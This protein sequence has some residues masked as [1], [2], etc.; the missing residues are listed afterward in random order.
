MGAAGVNAN[1]RG[2]AFL[3]MAPACPILGGPWS[4]ERAF[5]HLRDARN[6]S[7]TKRAARIVDTHTLFAVSRL[8]R[9]ADEAH[10]SITTFANKMKC[11]TPMS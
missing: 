5:G 6:A 10:R 9:Q 11:V 7:R 8:C 2:F 1:R 4:R 3:K